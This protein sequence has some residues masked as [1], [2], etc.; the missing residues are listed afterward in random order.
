MV[1]GQTGQPIGANAGWRL[2]SALNGNGGALIDLGVYIVQAHRYITGEE[3]V[4]VQARTWWPRQSHFHKGTEAS[5]SWILE[6]PS[7]ALAYGAMSWDS[8]NV[9]RYRV[10][11]TGGWAELDP[12]VSFNRIRGRIHRRLGQELELPANDYNQFAGE[13]NAMAVCVLSDTP[14]LIDGWEGMADIRPIR[15]LYISAETGKLVSLA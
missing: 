10:V 6:F 12:A 11:G 13:L 5:A 14:P 15:A 7:G 9:S 3:P 1:E 2:D 4:V 8:D